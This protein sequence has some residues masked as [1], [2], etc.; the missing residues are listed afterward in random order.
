M[1]VK[2]IVSD[3]NK[4][5]YRRSDKTRNITLGMGALVETIRDSKKPKIERFV[6][7]VEL[8]TAGA[9]ETWR[10]L[11]RFERGQIDLEGLH[12]VFNRR[13]ICGQ[14]AE[15]IRKIASAYANLTRDELDWRLLNEI[16]TAH[17]SGKATAIISASYDYSIDETLRAGGA[18]GIFDEMIANKLL[19]D[20]S[21]RA[22][23][24]T[25]EIYGKKAEILGELLERKGIRGSET[26]CIGDCEDDFAF[27]R[28]VGNTRFIVSF[29][30]KEEFR[31]RV[32]KAGAFVPK[33]ET[34]LHNYID[35]Q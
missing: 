26:L 16:K 2:A 13:Y 29:F 4:T 32:G 6:R 30:A 28:V 11:R 24:F 25:S 31:R 9:A 17:E 27:A 18:S 19:V 35:S 22:Y 8:G 7:A 3:W 10:S 12:E 1:V 20:E 21:G 34:E 33:N 5:L 23:G 15:D 14:R